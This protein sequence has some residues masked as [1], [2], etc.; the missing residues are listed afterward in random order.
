MAQ[1]TDQNFS[2]TAMEF[3][4]ADGFPVFFKKIDIM[5]IRAR[6]KMAPSYLGGKIN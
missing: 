6:N 2:A 4:G 5:L 3:Y 1:S